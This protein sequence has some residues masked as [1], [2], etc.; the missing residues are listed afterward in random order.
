[1]LTKTEQFNDDA[2]WLKINTTAT[3]GL[4]SETATT[5]EHY[6]LQGATGDLFTVELKEKGRDNVRLF[7]GTSTAGDSISYKFSTNAF[8]GVGTNITEYTSELL[9]DG[10]IRLRV[11]RNAVASQVRVV[12]LD[13]AANSYAGDITKGVFA[14]KADLRFANQ[15][16]NLPA[17]QRVN[18]STDYDTTGFLPYL[19]FTSTDKMSV[20]A[21]VRKLSDTY[22]A[23]VGLSVD[24]AANAGSFELAS[25]SGSFSY[26]WDSK[27]T[28]AA[29]ANTSGYAAP[30]TNSLTALGDISGDRATLRVN[31]AQVA[32]STADQGTGNFSNNPLYIGRRAGA[33]LPFN[34]QLYSMV[35][36]GKAV[37]AGELSSTETYV[38]TKTGV[39]I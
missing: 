16:V 7:V 19:S 30:I 33:S 18:T 39:L 24:T 13:G 1:L 29:R 32:Q 26:L 11:K 8:S 34:G 31:G 27:G 37:T 3:S 14:R 38:A 36:V 20:F 15:G 23:I 35:I 2:V 9:S 5:G 12:L 28:V 25:F 21:G 22:A 6:T 4:I 10:Y 17:Y